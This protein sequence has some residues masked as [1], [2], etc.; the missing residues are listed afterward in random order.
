MEPVHYILKEC[1]INKEMKQKWISFQGAL[2]VPNDGVCT[3]TDLV[4]IFA[5]KAKQR[6]KL[7]PQYS[8]IDRNHSGFWIAAIVTLLST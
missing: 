1:V 2:W 6:G 5:K 7:D 3:A 4:A 8:K